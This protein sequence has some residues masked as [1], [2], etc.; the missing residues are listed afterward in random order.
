MPLMHCCD[1]LANVTLEYNSAMKKTHLKAG[2]LDVVGGEGS[3]DND[4]WSLIVRGVHSNS[5]SVGQEWFAK[6]G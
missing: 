2:G 3:L 1:R 5:P 6:L 4:V